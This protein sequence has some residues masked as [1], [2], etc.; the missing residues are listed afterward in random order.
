MGARLQ[1]PPD[2][3]HFRSSTAGSVSFEY[4]TRLERLFY[5]FKSIAWVICRNLNSGRRGSS[6][7]SSSRYPANRAGCI[8]D[9]DRAA[10]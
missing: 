10:R 1:S 9:S 6:A 5:A 2:T 7:P 8:G 3:C 4:W